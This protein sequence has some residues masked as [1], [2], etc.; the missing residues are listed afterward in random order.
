[1]RTRIKICGVTD[2]GAAAA[3]VAAGADAV[4]LVFHP[5]SARHLELAQAAAIAEAARAAGP[6]TATVAVLVN[7]EAALVRAII[8]QV[9]PSHLQFHG[10]EAGDFCA[11]FGVPYIKALRVKPGAGADLRAFENRHPAA[12]GIL[13]DTHRDGVYGGSGETFDW[14]RAGDGRLP[15][16]LAGGLDAENAAA[17]IAQV[18]P[19]AV[20]VSSG[21]E[22]SPGR[23]DA[24]KIRAFCR[25]VAMADAGAAAGD[26]ATVTV[27]A[28]AAA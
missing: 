12:R 6:F 7:P 2:A 5:P 15:L 18:K 9:G 26:A 11:G 24:A 23:K 21:V 1:M 3:A 13:L 19:Y 16:I 14:R 17:A 28:T 4:G 25:A 22:V 20:D 27:T 8:A 10:E